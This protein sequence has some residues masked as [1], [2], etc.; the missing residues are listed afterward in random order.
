MDDTFM[1]NPITHPLVPSQEG[2]QNAL[3]GRGFR[4]GSNKAIKPASY[5]LNVTAK[6]VLYNKICVTLFRLNIITS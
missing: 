2:R 6:Q 3:R 4:G 1:F 5:C